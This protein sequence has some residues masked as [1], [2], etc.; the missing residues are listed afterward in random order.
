MTNPPYTMLHSL[1]TPMTGYIEGYYGRLLT[2]Q[3]RKQL[4]LRVA[5][6][7]MHAY[8][9]APKEDPQ[10][11][12]HWRTPYGSA[13]L[14]DWQDLAQLAQDKKLVLIAGIS[15]GLDF[16][17]NAAP[18][19][20]ASAKAKAKDND[21]DF[22]LLVGKMKT[23]TKGGVQACLMFDDIDPL[24]A[25]MTHAGDGGAG[26]NGKGDDRG[27]RDGGDGGEA[28]GRQHAMLANRLGEELDSPLFLVPR[29]YADELAEDSPQYLAAFATTLAKQHYVFYCGSHIVAHHLDLPQTLIAHA[30]IATNRLVVWDNLYAH[31]YCPR[32]LFL[33]KWRP[34]GDAR[35]VMLN[36][37]GMEATDS[38][39][40]A[41]M[42]GRLALG[43]N[44][45]NQA[46]TQAWQEALRAAGVPQAFFTI[47]HAFDLP[48]ATP[49]NASDTSGDIKHKG[50]YNYADMLAA[51]E[52]LVW[53]WKSPLA[54]EWYPYLMGLRGD[55]LMAT[56][57]ADALRQAKIMPPILHATMQFKGQFRG[58]F[59]GQSRG[60]S[61]MQSRGQKP[62]KA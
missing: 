38:L 30:G 13:W 52:E 16:D 20:K 24:N 18:N 3:A 21:N 12:S 49:A 6:L 48:P 25:G 5:A 54:R 19:T 60:K 36:P 8:L 57:K 1:P 14:A 10:H 33:G 31:D 50:E 27:D 59:S 26:G 42:A 9:Y 41:I 43:D 46:I 2:P 22:A 23:L 15:P 17:F 32:R 40:L 4:L 11:R 58:Q 34:V 61:R 37:T 53:R 45:S 51:V 39:L 35:G 44:A 55:I 62:S 29:I 28:E 47:A 7:G 56:G